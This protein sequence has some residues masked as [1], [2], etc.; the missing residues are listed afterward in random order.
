MLSNLLTL[1]FLGASVLA[2]P[3]EKRQATDEAGFT[4]AANAL[5]SAYIPP[6]IAIQL[7]GPIQSAASAA[8]ATGDIQQIVND[9][10]LAPT[11]PPYLSDAIPSQYLPNVL[12]L[13]S[14]ISELRGVAS[15][16]IAGAPVI[17]TDSTG[18]VVTT[19]TKGLVTTT[20]EGGSTILAITGQETDSAGSTLPAAILST[21]SVLDSAAAA[22]ATTGGTAAVTTTGT[23]SAT[24][25]TTDTASATETTTDTASATETTTAAVTETETTSEAPASTTGAGNP[26]ALPPSA[27]GL[28]GLI[29]LL[30]AL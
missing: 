3:Q 4:S 8:G 28:I 19:G 10:L 11:P 29:G 26:A 12:S 6:E 30:L 5:I 1:A 23:A 22:A 16:G 14:A 17:G 15:T 27:G 2:A 7:A 13:E 20:G 21:V 9:A 18:G 24:E 25:T